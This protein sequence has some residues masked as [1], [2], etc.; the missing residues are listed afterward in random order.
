MVVV[1]TYKEL[2]EYFEMFRR[3]NC[4][5]LIVRSK[6]GYGKTSSLRAVMSDEDYIFINTHSTPLSTFKSLWDKRDRPV[7]FDDIDA[8]MSSPIMVSMLKAL[9]DTS[10]IKELHY[11]STTSLLGEAPEKFTTASNVCILLNEFDAKNKSLAPLLDRG[12]FV[13]FTPSRKEIVKRI[14]EIAK[15]Q[16]SADYQVCVQF[17]EEH[18]DQINNLSLRTYS[19]AVQLYRDNPSNWKQR[20][21]AMIGF[22]EKIICYLSLKEKYRSDDERLKNGWQWSRATYYRVKDEV[23]R[24]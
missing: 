17:I 2:K 13:E 8:I 19:K 6:A 22:D 1:T 23:E 7:V 10:P 21:L 9:A 24:V 11:N 3:Q 4:D 16:S 20:F 18:R 14:K 5:L 15:S 12:F